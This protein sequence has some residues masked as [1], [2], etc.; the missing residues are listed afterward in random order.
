MW[1]TGLDGLRATEM[2]NRHI[3]DAEQRVEW[4]NTWT[5]GEMGLNIEK[6]T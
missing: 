2:N 3:A 6:T 1:G 5:D 4:I